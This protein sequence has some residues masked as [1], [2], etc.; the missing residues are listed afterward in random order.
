MVER[1]KFVAF[2][3]VA[4][5]KKTREAWDARAREGWREGGKPHPFFRDFCSEHMAELGTDVLDIGCGNGI[6]LLPLA[7][8]NFKVTGI[9]ISHEMLKK[10]RDALSAKGLTAKLV[11]GVTTHLP[12]PKNSFDFL[13]SL[14]VMHHNNIEGVRA[15]FSEATRVL[16]SGHY[17]M[18]QVRSV[19]D[20]SKLREKRSD[21]ET[22]E[23]DKTGGMK[24][25]ARHY[26]TRDELVQLGNE[27]G[28]DAIVGPQEAPPTG[29]E[30]GEGGR[31]RWWVV[32]RKR[33]PESTLTQE[34]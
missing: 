3:K 33:A 15:S 21:T 29:E 27:N 1:Q 24:G 17:F 2:D 6:Y 30:T 32:Y 10:S 34:S 19:N 5:E 4:H 14:G 9:D 18:L 28:L 23:A 16:R 13:I 22:L 26:F 8:N 31:L 25:V 12:F 7:K 11:Q 20:T